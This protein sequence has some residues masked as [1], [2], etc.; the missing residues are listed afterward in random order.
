MALKDLLLKDKIVLEKLAVS[1]NE[2]F[3]N[4]ELPE[5]II[6]TEPTKKAYGHFWGDKW[7]HGEEN[8]SEINISPIFF[9]EGPLN[10]L[11]TLHHECIHL[12]N[13]INDVKDFS[14]KRHNKRFK[15]ACDEHDLY[16]EKVDDNRGFATPNDIDL[17]LETWLTWYKAV[18]VELKLDEHFLYAYKPKP[19]N[20]A[21]RVN[22][23][24]ICTETENRFY[25]TDKLA[26]Q[27]YDGML[28]LTSPY[29]SGGEVT[30]A[31]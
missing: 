2:T 20:K 23:A 25:L 9:G 3:F 14:G 31:E 15:K 11:I 29:V 5:I 28:E 7:K 1:I 13:F 8:I 30:P 4:G 16:C 10:V 21:P 26:K 12:F 19:I 17:Q 22:T 6:N 24:F 18:V 27:Y